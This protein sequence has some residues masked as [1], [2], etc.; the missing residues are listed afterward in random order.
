VI[1]DNVFFCYPTLFCLGDTTVSSSLDQLVSFSR[2]AVLL[3]CAS[4]FTFSCL[5]ADFTLPSRSLILRS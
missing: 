2:Y 4:Y 5:Y 3:F 1:G